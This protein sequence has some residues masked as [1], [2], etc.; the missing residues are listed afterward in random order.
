METLS[1]PRAGDPDPGDA[2]WSR[3]ADRNPFPE[4]HPFDLHRLVMLGVDV[5]VVLAVT[6]F[7]LGQLGLGNILLNNTPTGGDMGAHVWGPLFL[8]DHLLP[9]FELSGWTPDWYD[10]F[11]A[12]QFYM[13][14]PSLAIVILNAG[15]HGWAAL[16]PAAAAIAIAVFA[17]R[18]PARSL[19]RR[20][21]IVL[22]IVVALFGVGMPYGVA[23]KI[24][25]V[26]G[27]LSLPVAAYALA[28]LGDLPFPTPALFA[29]GT[30]PFLFNLEPKFNSTGNI[31]GGNVMSTMAGEF[32]FSISVTFAVL[33]LGVVLAGL[34]TGRYRWLAAVLLALT[35]LCHVIPAIWAMGAAALTL[36]VWPSRKRLWWLATVLPVG[37]LLSAFWTFPFYARSAYVNDFGWEKLPSGITKYSA[38]DVLFNDPEGIRKAIIDQYLAPKSLYWVIALAL[39]GLVVSIVLRIRVGLWLALT[40]FSVAVAFVVAPEARLW[41]ARLLPFYYLGLCLLAALG[42]AELARSIAILAAPDPEHPRLG[43]TVGLTGLALLLVLIVI[44]LPLNA[45]PGETATASGFSWNGIDVE[46]NYSASWARHNFTGLEG[47]PAY[48]EYEAFMSTMQHIGQTNGCGRAMWEYDDP[49]LERYGSP[50]TPMLL[51]MWTDG[52]IGSMEGLFFESSTT[53]PFHFVNQSELSFHCSCAQRNLPYAGLDVPLGVKHLQML[54]VKYYAASTKTAIDEANKDPDLTL[55]ATSEPWHIYEVADAPLVQPLANQPAVLTADTS[56]LD[57][58]YGSSSPHP[59]EA[60]LTPDGPEQKANGPAME[61][62]TDPQQW[63][64][65]LAA[66]GPSSWARVAPGQTPAATPEPTV[67]V[68]NVHEGTDTIDF[69]VDKPGTPILVKTSYFPN[70]KVD[71]AAGPYRVTPNLMV[72]IPNSTHVH[73]HYGRTGVEYTSYVLTLLGI[74]LVIVLAKRPPL[75][76]PATA[77]GGDDVLVRFLADDDDDE[78]D[79]VEPDG[80]PFAEPP[81]E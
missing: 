1:E 12:Y 69:D 40:T 53:T 16:L 7:V 38:W 44:G 54:G 32:S 81:L 77:A 58:V 65:Y 71:G 14:L 35:V 50:M 80:E 6:G 26:L 2:G 9:H 57:W 74:A 73:L 24:V 49:V 64:V 28:K 5:F 8:R 47:K 30:L 67:N 41:N 66:D 17:V 13:V 51:P 25:T 46:P 59:N 21:L 63:N 76:M 62:Y 36:V 78:Y 75:K 19:R 48:P 37:A 10:G 4:F 39:V 70:W 29:M 55:I 68:S 56:G 22:A 61:W 34:R 52:C 60:K 23:F 27:L 43:L 79:E 31:I 15:L 11:P 18:A 33:F 3:P 20:A 72:V 42:V 45:I